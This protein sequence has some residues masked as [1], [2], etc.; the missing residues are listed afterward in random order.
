MHKDS[1]KKTLKTQEL[2]NQLK[3]AL[4]DYANL[5]RRVEDEKGQVVDWAKSYLLVKFLPVLD[6]L[7]RVQ[8]F[9]L[10][11]GPDPTKHGL[12]LALEQ[13]RRILRDEQIEEIETSGVF[14]PKYHEAIEVTEGN[15]ENKIVEVV[16]K[17][18]KLGDKILRPAKVKVE[19]KKKIDS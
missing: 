18:Y 14:D 12:S 1:K 5:E 13:V 19:K 3:R 10:K 8:R 2:E 7:E 4:A 15:S 6:S 9:V 16:E 11:E 17:G